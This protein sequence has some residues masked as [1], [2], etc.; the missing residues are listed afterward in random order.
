MSKSVDCCG[1]KT[2]QHG[3][4]AMI[5]SNSLNSWSDI[6]LL[7]HIR[8]FFCFAH[9]RLESTRAPWTNCQQNLSLDILTY[10]PSICPA[11]SISCRKA[12]YLIMHHRQTEVRE[13]EDTF[14]R[15]KNI[16]LSAQEVGRRPHII[17]ST[18][19][20]QVTMHLP[21]Q[22]APKFKRKGLNRAYHVDIM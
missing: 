16:I 22:L 12:N 6:P 4:F 17:L 10:H 3:L 7:A 9:F 18:H 14:V 2:Y 8:L 1:R 11:A 15:N 13:F 5:S 20:F 21:T 19:P